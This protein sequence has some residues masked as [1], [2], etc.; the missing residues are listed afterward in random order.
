[1]TGQAVRQKLIVHRLSFHHIIEMP[2]RIWAYT[3]RLWS[4]AGWSSIG[5]CRWTPLFLTTSTFECRNGEARSVRKRGRH[6]STMG[7]MEFEPNGSVHLWSSIPY[8]FLDLE[9]LWPLLQY[10]PSDNRPIKKWVAEAGITKHI[11]YHCFRHS[12]ATLQLAGGTDIYTV[13]KMLGHT[14]VR[15]TQ[16][17]AKV[18]DAK[19]EEA[20][21]TIKLDLPYCWL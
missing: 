7:R 18:V 1:M 10:Q 14:N 2:V 15:T 5:N 21:K 16:V 11:T 9:Y 4:F 17:Y 12:Y 20:T 19:K 13:S 6:A 3:Q 8:G